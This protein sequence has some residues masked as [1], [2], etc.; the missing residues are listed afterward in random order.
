VQE[1]HDVTNQFNV[2]GDI[3]PGFSAYDLKFLLLLTDYVARHIYNRG[4]LTRIKTIHLPAG[5]S[6]MITGEL[7]LPVIMMAA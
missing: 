3:K 2:F 7:F 1:D 6:W 5:F 4:F